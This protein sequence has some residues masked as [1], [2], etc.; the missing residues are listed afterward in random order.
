MPL[1]KRWSQYAKD[2]VS[3]EYD[4]YGVYELGNDWDIL[5]IGEDKIYTRLMSHFP[6]SS[7]PVVGSSHYRV[8]YTGSKEQAQKRQNAELKLYK[9][10]YGRLPRFNQRVR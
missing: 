10:H 1:A 9:R 7:E 5:Y 2:Y 8:E 4:N 6:N 3:R